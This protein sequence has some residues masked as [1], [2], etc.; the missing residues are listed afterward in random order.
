MNLPNAIERLRDVL[1]LQHKAISTEDSYVYW[2]R[3]YV[4]ALNTMPGSLTSE[5]KLEN[6]LTSLARNRDLAASTQNQAFNA[7][8]FF[9]NDVLRQPLQN[10]DAL[11][12]KR[13]ARLRH[14]TCHGTQL[15]GDHHGLF[16]CGKFECKE[17]VG[18]H[19][20]KDRPIFSAPGMTRAP[21]LHVSDKKVQ[22]HRCQK[23]YQHFQRRVKHSE[24]VGSRLISTGLPGGGN[25]SALCG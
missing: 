2:L 25:C 9:Y 23:L 1:R 16:A 8:L 21:H 6:F 12:A 22:F 13:P 7:I 17:S 14:P 4:T 5:Q 15:A 20:G 10:I 24:H 18:I 19:P 11:R 3:R